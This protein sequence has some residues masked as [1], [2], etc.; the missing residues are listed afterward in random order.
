MKISI[1]QISAQSGY[2]VATVS[3][4]LNNKKGVNV[5]TSRK[6]IEAAE[7]L[8][9]FQDHG[10]QCIKVLVY[11]KNKHIVTDTPFFSSLISGIEKECRANGYETSICH[12]DTRDPDYIN[13]AEQILNDHALGLLVLA[14]EMSSEDVMLVKK[15]MS[16]TVLIDSYFYEATMDTVMIDNVGSAFQATTFLIDNGHNHI[17]YL[18]SSVDIRNFYFRRL[19]FERAMDEAHLALKPEWVYHISPT[20]DGA[21]RDMIHYLGQMS[22]KQLPTAF[23][24]DNDIIALGSMKALKEQGFQIPGDISII[25]FDDLPFSKAF[26]PS[27]TTIKVSTHE[28]GKSAVRLL[29]NKIENGGNSFTTVNI[30]TEL[31]KRNSV[32][33]LEE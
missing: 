29:L 32:R 24:A 10:M 9:Y 11:K 3:N 19:G 25:G 7:S 6:I 27:L 16:P 17:G 8:G 5:Q 22:G 21:Y 14:T 13:Y 20:M 2:S 30:G 18:H 12:I 23:F 1:K 33:K 28:M 26:S 4:V 15:S 31:M